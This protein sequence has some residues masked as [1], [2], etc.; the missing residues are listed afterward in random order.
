MKFRS[1][2]KLLPVKHKSDCVTTQRWKWPEGLEASQLTQAGFL[3][4][5][6]FL[7]SQTP[8]E[9]LLSGA[10]YMQDTEDQDFNILKILLNA[11]SQLFKPKGTENNFN[12]SRLTTQEKHQILGRLW[13][14]HWISAGWKNFCI[15]VQTHCCR[16]RPQCPHTM[17]QRKAI[18]ILQAEKWGSGM[19]W[20]HSTPTSVM[21]Y[22]CSNLAQQQSRHQLQP[23]CSTGD[24]NHGPWSDRTAQKASS[25]PEQPWFI[26]MLTIKLLKCHNCFCVKW[27]NVK[28][29]R[30]VIA[31]QPL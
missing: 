14:D 13:I 1:P 4:Q 7:T 25:N 28:T 8:R 22:P 2:R 20:T 12:L 11:S 18:A 16:E 10:I 15:R 17:K 30:A 19:L 23:L 6:P 31:V 9:M 29:A 27:L 26:S 3:W 24:Q 21:L 5:L